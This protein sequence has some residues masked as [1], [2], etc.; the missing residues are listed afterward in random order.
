MTWEKHNNRTDGKHQ[1]SETIER[2]GS[3]H[4]QAWYCVTMKQQNR[5]F[6]CSSTLTR[7]A[8]PSTRFKKK[9]I[10]VTFWAWC[11]C[12]ASPVPGVDCG[13]VHLAVILHETLTRQENLSLKLLLGGI[14]VY[15]Y[16]GL[17]PPSPLF[18]SKSHLFMR[19]NS[20]WGNSG[21]V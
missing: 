7:L 6:S 16:V 1:R 8:A 21:V 13:P 18:H 10:S 11:I 2:H 9:Y 12:Y 20:P 4:L 15:R 19:E 5:S 17:A 3:R 14:N